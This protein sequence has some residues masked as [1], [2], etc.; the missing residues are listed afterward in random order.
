LRYPPFW[1][2]S[3]VFGSKKKKKR[4][5]IYCI[6]MNSAASKHQFL[7]WI[8]AIHRHHLLIHLDEYPKELHDYLLKADSVLS[9]IPI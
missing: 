1:L 9:S 4:R 6:Q 5:E 3:G 7:T 2:D 8:L